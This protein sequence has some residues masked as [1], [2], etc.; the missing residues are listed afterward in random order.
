M[1]LKTFKRKS[2][3]VSYMQ[4]LR[5]AIDSELNEIYIFKDHNLKESEGQLSNS[6]WICNIESYK[7]S[8]LYKS[9]NS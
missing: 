6:F 4:S 5:A 2:P 9:S 8:R 7:W 1:N 3:Q